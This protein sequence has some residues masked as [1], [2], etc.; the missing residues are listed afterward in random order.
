MNM[1]CLLENSV[2]RMAVHQTVKGY[3][4][5]DKVEDHCRYEIPKSTNTPR[6]IKVVKKRILRNNKRSMRRMASELN[7]SPTLMKRIVKH[8][9]GF[10]SYKICLVHIE[11]ESGQSLRKT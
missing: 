4:E 8:E 9:L 10:Y 3:Q 7:I 1:L 6:V 5:L 11:E 2:T